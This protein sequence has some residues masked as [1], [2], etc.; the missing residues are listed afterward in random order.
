MLISKKITDAINEQIGNEFSASL[1]YVSIAAHFEAETLLQLAKHFYRQAEEERDHAL[2]FV[3]Y[4]LD[5]GGRVT[6]P[7]VPAPVARFSTAA[8]AVQLSLDQ[9]LKVTKQINKLVEMAKK[10]NDYTTDNFLQW[11]VREQLEEVS[12]MTDLLNIIHRAGEQNLLRVE[13]YLRGHPIVEEEST[14]AGAT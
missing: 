3:K 2:K 4:V 10:E 6:I 13:E 9:E 5:T 8:A 7:A 12:S 11:F 1:Q 14:E